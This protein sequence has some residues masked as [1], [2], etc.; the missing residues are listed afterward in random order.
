V[1]AD[2]L[3]VTFRFVIGI[4]GQ[5]LVWGASETPDWYRVVT[6]DGDELF[7]GKVECPDRS[8]EDDPAGWAAYH[9]FGPVRAIVAEAAAALALKDRL[10]KEFL[11]QPQE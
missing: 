5:Q 6:K 9:M 8:E 2:G 4:Q 7:E 3:V 1:G 11:A 10:H